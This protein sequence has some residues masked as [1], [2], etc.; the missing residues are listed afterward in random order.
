MKQL[1]VIGVGVLALLHTDLESKSYFY[2]ALLPLIDLLFVGYLLFVIL[3]WFYRLRGGGSG[4]DGGF[5]D[6]GGGD[7]GGGD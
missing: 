3:S 7:G 5:G 4:S 6:F 2:G 1:L